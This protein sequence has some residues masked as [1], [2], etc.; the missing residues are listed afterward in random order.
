MSIRK[1]FIW[2]ILSIISFNISILFL[3]KK[4]DIYK[5]DAWYSKWYYWIIAFV[6]GFIPGLIM[7]F[8][9]VLQTNV[10]IALKYLWM[11]LYMDWL[12]NYSYI[13]MEYFYYY[14]VIYL[15]L[16]YYWSF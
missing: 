8:I 12:F 7:L 6:F 15:Y 14:D 13:G 5:E 1:A 4:L 9:L 16:L 3:G 11:S 2:F 10:K